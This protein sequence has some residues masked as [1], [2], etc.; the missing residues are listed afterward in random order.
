MG[1]TAGDG[2]TAGEE[3]VAGADGV[4]VAAAADGSPEEPQAVTV[5]GTSARITTVVASELPVGRMV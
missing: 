5:S 1:A 4:E 3:A 2:D